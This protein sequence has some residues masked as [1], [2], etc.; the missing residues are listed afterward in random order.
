MSCGKFGKNHRGARMSREFWKKRHHAGVK[1]AQN[2]GENRSASS[3]HQAAVWRKHTIVWKNGPSAI[4]LNHKTRKNPAC[5]NFVVFFGK[6]PCRYHKPNEISPS[7]VFYRLRFASLRGERLRTKSCLRPLD[8][9]RRPFR[10]YDS[11][12]DPGF[13]R[14]PLVWHTP[15]IEPI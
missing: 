7:S 2:G 8:S 3:M 15:G 1:K 6:F 9:G 12:G 14:L 5:R 13:R 10:K 4:A 11:G